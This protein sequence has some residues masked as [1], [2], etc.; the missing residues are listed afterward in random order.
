MSHHN[1]SNGAGT[2]P[3][4]VR[5]RFF[6]GKLMDVRHFEM[7]QRYFLQKGWL[8]NR[9]GL[10]SGV[11]CGLEVEAAGDGKLLIRPGVAIDYC[12]RE[13]V[14]GKPYCLEHPLQPTDDCGCPDGD[15]VEKGSVTIC[16][17]YHECDTE[18]SPVLV[19][20]CDTKLDCKPSAVLERFRLLV[21]RGLPDDLPPR[22]T[23]EQCDAIFPHDPPD[24]FDRRR[25]A[26]ETLHGPCAPCLDDCVVLATI[27]VEGE[28]LLVDDCT[29]RTVV[30]SNELLLELLLCLA[31]RVDECCGKQPPVKTLPVVTAIWPPNAE[32]LSPS[33][34]IGHSPQAPEWFK[35]FLDQ[36]RLELTFNHQMD[37]SQL[38]DPY[39]W[40]RFWMLFEPD[41]PRVQLK[42]YDLTLDSTSVVA[43][44]S[45][46]VY[47]I[48][49]LQRD[50][51]KA[52]ELN[53]ETKFL[54]EL[55][56]DPGD[57][58]IVDTTSLLL[59]ADFKGT[60]LA[61]GRF[62][63]IW[64]LDVDT[65]Q[66]AED[67]FA[68]LGAV[69]LQPPSGN[70]SEG[71][72][73]D[74]TFSVVVKSQQVAPPVVLSHWP[75]N[76][77]R[78]TRDGSAGASVEWFKRWLEHPQ[79]E[80]TFDR[81]MQDEQLDN[82]GDWLRLWQAQLEGEQQVAVRRLPLTLAEL[83][84]DDSIEP[85]GETAVYSVDTGPPNQETRYLVQI[86]SENQVIVAQDDA[87][88]L[89]AEFIGTR[90]GRDTLDQIWNE[91]FVILGRPLWDG[92]H[93]IP[94]NQLPRSGDGVEG[95]DFNLAFEIRIDR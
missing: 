91:E 15:P 20:D 16:L 63:E 28:K 93:G 43:G 7:E 67:L 42:R 92:F 14:V 79:L 75:P 12:G 23:E 55:L 56:A 77:A 21:H 59:D 10:G 54:V 18:P 1:G 73:F 39:E 84:P 25:A 48:D 68:E 58:Q 31:H 36:P 6:Y 51:L 72:R 35:E 45:A 50:L 24:D 4:P 83:R 86:R 81:K 53:R 71:G 11:L 9:V 29:Y 17:A 13:I 76:G 2:L 52:L 62:D 47:T 33:Q 66:L 87:R 49:E 26:C 8:L 80:V 70:Q 57:P 82:P 19:A 3:A 65:G 38:A 5:N 64:P 60:T 32:I 90:L 74:A 78:L 27:T 46:A 34:G 44:G 30:Y 69:N 85:G 22:L 89:D 95:G 41:P 94:S 61:A 40:L 37:L 88:E